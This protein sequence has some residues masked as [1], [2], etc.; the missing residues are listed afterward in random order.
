MEIR[1]GISD[2]LRGKICPLISGLQKL[3]EGREDLY[4]KLIN[5]INECDI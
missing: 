3:R 5:D 4:K 1:K 2:L